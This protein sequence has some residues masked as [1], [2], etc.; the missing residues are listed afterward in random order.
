MAYL[1]VRLND[2]LNND[3]TLNSVFQFQALKETLNQEQLEMY[4]RILAE[5]IELDQRALSN[6]VTSREN[7]TDVTEYISSDMAPLELI[8][9][10][11]QGD[12]RELVETFN[13]VMSS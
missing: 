10:G 8:P 2:S 13:F 7:G 4:N 9:L 1:I 11:E 6:E 5:N 3:K 12:L